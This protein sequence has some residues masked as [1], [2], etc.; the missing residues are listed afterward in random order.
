V[1]TAAEQSGS[2]RTGTTR[3]AAL[4]MSAAAGAAA[5]LGGCT[6]YGQQPSS[7]SGGSAPPAATDEPTA[8]ASA[9]AGGGAAAK[10]ALAKT[11]D[12]PVGGGKVFTDAAVVVTQPTKGTFKAF[13]TVCT[14]QGC[15]IDEVKNGTMNCPCHGSKF[16]IAD[17]AV[18]AGPA[19]KPLP[20]KKINVDG[21]S[22]TL[23]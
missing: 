3:R 11:S 5:V 8:E 14:H 13:S 4:T 22:V 19:P 12:I 21:D 23:A 2:A 17:G 9:D 15:P 1:S 7:G 18:A 6:V 20:A 16:K 10:P